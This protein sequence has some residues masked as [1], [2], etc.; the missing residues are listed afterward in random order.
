M[1]HDDR[2]LLPPR[3]DDALV[4]DALVR[5]DHPIKMAVADWAADQLPGD[6][7][8]ERD[9][10]STFFEKGWL[11]CADRGLTGAL[12]PE[13][14]GGRGVDVVTATLELEG[15]GLGCRDTGLGFALASQIL[16]F[17][18]AILRFGSEEQQAALLPGVCAGH[19]IGAFCITEHET[20]SDA[21]A[22]TATAERDGDDYVLHGHKAHITLAP[23][24]DVAIV[25]AKTNPAA[26]AWGIS[27]FLVHTDRPGVTRSGVIEKM[28]LRTTPFGDLIL[29]G[30]RA[31]EADRL[32]PEGAG[33]S[34]FTTCMESERGLIFATQ[35]GAAERII[36][37]A[38]D[39]ARSRQAFGQPIGGFQAVSHRI[40]DMK[41]AHEL[42]RVQMIK[43]AALIGRGD[44]ATMDAAI[45]KL[46]ASEAV[47]DIGLAAARVHGARGYLTDHDVERDVRDAL[48]GLVY[49]GT[50]D[51]QK[52]L[53]ARLL[54]VS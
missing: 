46:V 38:I 21:Y 17:T 29:D 20:G 8:I 52:N 14:F 40:A 51:I 44:T 34:I 32:G 53:I 9:K 25:F 36:G 41:V 28:G 16:S 26:G 3:P 42:A 5:A 6:D 13:R 15:L 50:S 27:A 7:L 19:T 54:R 37:E 48:G 49:S 47:A 22:M 35:L 2:G 1:Q 11:A 39:R 4:V 18:D 24:A 43:T 45:S 31:P 33:V 23:A 10:N 30:Y 12:V